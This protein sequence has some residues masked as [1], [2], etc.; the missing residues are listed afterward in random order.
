MT[1]LRPAAVAAAASAW[2]SQL[3]EAAHVLH[4]RKGLLCGV[5]PDIIRVDDR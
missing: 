1:R 4:R 3:V 5:N 2:L